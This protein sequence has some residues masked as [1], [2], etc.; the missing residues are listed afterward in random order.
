MS[1]QKIIERIKKLLRLAARST[2]EGEAANALSQ[3]QKLMAKH[4]LDSHAPEL[5]DV[6]QADVLSKLKANKPAAYFSRL[7]WLVAESFGCHVHRA[8][9]WDGKHRVVF[10]GHNERPEVATY[11][12]EVLERQLLKSRKE[13]LA[14]LNKRLKR[15]TKTA[16]ADMFCEGWVTAVRSKVNA[17]A[18]SD[19]ESTQIKE[20]QSKKHGE[21]KTLNVRS[22]S[23]KKARGG[24]DNAFS[25]GYE[26]GKQ[27]EL[28]HGVNGRESQ[29][30]T[31][32]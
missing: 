25:S 4:G 30:L 9:S 2:N 5:S 1:N 6:C 29:K 21:L 17:L 11:V 20:F 23:E 26:S 32:K 28:N 18:L 24:A 10:T 13:F 16:R 19:A 12:Y 7:V 15:T 8:D 22:A 31:M 27:A 3:A 14:T